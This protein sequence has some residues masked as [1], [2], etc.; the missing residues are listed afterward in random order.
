MKQTQEPITTDVPLGL[1]EPAPIL[2]WRSGLELL[3]PHCFTA[4]GFSVYISERAALNRRPSALMRFYKV[5]S[6]PYRVPMED[7]IAVA[8]SQGATI[9]KVYDESL[10]VIEEYPL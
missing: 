1:D 5:V 6:D 3:P 9:L 4:L 7:A 8:R 2:V 10:R